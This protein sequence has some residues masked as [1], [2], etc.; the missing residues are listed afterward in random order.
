MVPPVVSPTAY[1][2][3]GTPHSEQQRERLAV[4]GFPQASDSTRAFCQPLYAAMPHPYVAH[5]DTH[6]TLP[7]VARLAAAY[8]ESAGVAFTLLDGC[9]VAGGG[10]FPLINL[11]Q[12]LGAVPARLWSEATAEHFGAIRTITADLDLPTDYASARPGLRL[13]LVEDEGLIKTQSWPLRNRICAGLSQQLMIKVEG[14]AVSVPP[15]L[16]E[17]W[18]TSAEQ[19][20]A[21]A[22]D[23]TLADSPKEARHL[24]KNTGERIV[25][26]TGNSCT[27]S[28]LRGLARN[29]HSGS[30]FGAAA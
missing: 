10:E 11:S 13:R 30:G 6:P 17:I 29:L 25:M 12:K 1:L 24:D 15:D 4:D 28:H 14:G 2:G 21:D 16:L 5:M 20:W 9:V 19:V 3:S 23:H 27:S 8:F 7:Q 26:I 22:L 18:S